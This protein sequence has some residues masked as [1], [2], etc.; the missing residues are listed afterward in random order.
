MSKS[1][2]V[3]SN[4]GQK[5]SI[6]SAANTNN[7]LLEEV[8]YIKNLMNTPTVAYIKNIINLYYAGHFK[9]VYN[10]LTTQV[11]ANLMNDIYSYRRDAVVYPT[12]EKVRNVLKLYLQLLTQQNQLYIKLV[13]TENQLAKV[14]IKANILNN[15]TELKEYIDKL[16]KTVYLFDIKP[17]EIV[18]AKIL[19]EH[20]AYVI[21]YGYPPGGVFDPEKLSVIIS[22]LNTT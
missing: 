10:L 5:S 15:M 12:Y 11:I 2:F 3:N 13:N 22:Q 9:E 16:N 7:L 21:A 18:P 4:L 20:A 6:S 1:I 8:N 17:Q 14:Q 19:P